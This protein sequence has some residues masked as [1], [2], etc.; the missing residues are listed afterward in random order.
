MDGARAYEKTS[1]WL[2]WKTAHRT[3]VHT[4]DAVIDAY[5]RITGLHIL[6]I[7]NHGLEDCV[8]KD[9]VIYDKVFYDDIECNCVHFPTALQNHERSGVQV[10]YAASLDRYPIQKCVFQWLAIILDAR[11]LKIK[12]VRPCYSKVLRILNNKVNN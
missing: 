6:C 9:T 12:A 1:L 7:S 2:V 4:I 10:C 5:L 11:R 8:A 3:D